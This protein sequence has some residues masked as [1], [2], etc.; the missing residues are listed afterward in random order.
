MIYYFQQQNL[1]HT[2]YYANVVQM[3]VQ[4]YKLNL[5]IHARLILGMKGILY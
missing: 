2:T 3:L 4:Y 5:K 1:I